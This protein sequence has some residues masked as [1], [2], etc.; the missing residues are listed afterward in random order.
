MRTWPKLTDDIITV[1]SLIYLLERVNAFRNDKAGGFNRKSK[2]HT[3]L[4]LVS[5]RKECRAVKS[6]EFVPFA[7]T[8]VT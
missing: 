7:R 3:L 1:R 5:Q 6:E 8:E 4:K 2:N